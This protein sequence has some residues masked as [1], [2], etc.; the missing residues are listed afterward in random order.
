MMNNVNTNVERIIAKI[1]NDFNPSDSDW[2][3]RVGA[4]C[5][6]AMNILGIMQTQSIKKKIPVKDRIAYSN[7][8]INTKDLIV[9]DS[10]GCIIKEADENECLCSPSTGGLSETVIV[11]TADNTTDTTDV[12]IN[13]NSQYDIVHVQAETINDKEWPGRY[14]VKEYGKRINTDR[15][16]VIINDKQ[17]ELNFD[18]DFIYIIY[19]SIKTEYSK[20]FNCELPVIPNNGLLIEAL[21]YYCM[22]K[23][24]TRGYK[25]PVF[26]LN[27]SQYGT[28]PY[29]MWNNIKE[30]AKRS[31]IIGEQ[32]DNL[33]DDEIWR[34]NFY[35]STFNPKRR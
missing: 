1:D 26:N 8:I 31:V 23:I 20:V 6:D 22:Y 35:I 28:N 30:E 3:P 27:A 32:K 29:F 5:I 18:T 34:D 10:N 15:N 14:N 24:L 19:K 9:C 21:T 17:L 16:Y 12:I 33:S 25:H 7:C 4:W 11:D 2:I 13:P